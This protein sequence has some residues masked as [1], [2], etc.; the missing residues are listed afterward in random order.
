MLAT[1][2]QL[3]FPFRRTP[4]EAK[5]EA[6]SKWQFRYGLP[7]LPKPQRRPRPGVRV[8]HEGP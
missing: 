8:L 1:P 6:L 2:R 3:K 4:T 7:P 5:L